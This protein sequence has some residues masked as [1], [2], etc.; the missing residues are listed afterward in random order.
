MIRSLGSDTGGSVR[1]P[2]SY[3]GIYGFKPSNGR[4]SRFGLIT[5]ASSLDTIGILSKELSL[6]K[7]AFQAMATSVT[8]K[9]I[10]PTH[11]MT[12]WSRQEP[13]RM[14]SFKESYRIGI[15][16][17]L[18]SKEICPVTLFS[19][20]KLL[21]AVALKRT[22]TFVPVSIPSLRV[23]LPVYYLT[24]FTEAASNLARYDNL[25]PFF[26]SS[27]QETKKISGSYRESAQLHRK[28]LFGM[29]VQKRILIG[30]RLASLGVPFPELT[31]RDPSGRVQ[32][33]KDSIFG[34]KFQSYYQSSMVHRKKMKLD[35]DLCYKKYQ[36]D[37]VISLT[38]PSEAPF[39]RDVSI[40]SDISKLNLE[41]S[42][43][44]TCD[45]FINLFHQMERQSAFT[46]TDCW[47]SIANYKHDWMTVHANLLGAPAISLPWLKGPSNFPVGIQLMTPFGSDEELFEL[48]AHL[49]DCLS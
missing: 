29:E 30:T 31:L 26:N 38:A 5:Y 6:I 18:F 47:V 23:A 37:G 12:F 14:K 25:R 32:Q 15:P 10:C 28:N 22:V 49:E 13:I 40:Q 39:V 43:K 11:D 21:D 9:S 48:A 46:D 27:Q 19:F 16:E 2:A 20:Y 1:L 7:S 34:G 42:A 45:S 8:A 4:I 3:C 24:S 36:L 41:E 44:S 33:R 17:E 35:M